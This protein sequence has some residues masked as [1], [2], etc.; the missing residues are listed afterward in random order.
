MIQDEI[1]V[2]N[3]LVE[4]GYCGLD[5]GTKMRI[6]LDSICMAALGA[7]KATILTWE[8]TKDKYSKAV[9]LPN[10]FVRQS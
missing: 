7:P 2:L 1:N 6:L 3:S 4:Y 8:C 10:D 9:L 5:S